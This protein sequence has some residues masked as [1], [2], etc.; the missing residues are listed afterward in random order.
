MIFRQFGKS[1]KGQSDQRLNQVKL[2]KVAGGFKSL[3]TAFRP[4]TMLELAYILL[5]I[6]CLQLP[7][8]IVLPL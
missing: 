8:E 7:V 2:S 3:M 4:D 5:P 1:L 6:Y